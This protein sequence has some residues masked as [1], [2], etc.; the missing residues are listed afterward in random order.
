MKKKGGLV[1]ALLPYR[2][3]ADEWEE[4]F[5]MTPELRTGTLKALL[6]PES[7]P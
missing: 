2:K 4:F 1:R 5:R 3:K 6:H 7:K